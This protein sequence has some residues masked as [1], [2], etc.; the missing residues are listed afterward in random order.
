MLIVSARKLCN[1]IVALVK[2]E[3]GDVLIHDFCWQQQDANLNAHS[4]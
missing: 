3:T 2:V 4:K 1:P